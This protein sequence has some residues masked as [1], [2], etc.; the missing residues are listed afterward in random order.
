[1]DIRELEKQLLARYPAFDAESWDHVG[2]SVGDPAAQVA[3]VTCALDATEANIR[4]AHDL[5]ANVLLTHH[6]V[7]IKAPTCFAPAAPEIPQCSSALYTAAQLGV[8]II[9]LHT[10]LD[11]SL[12]ARRMPAGLFG[13]T[14]ICSLENPDDPQATGLGSIFEIEEA[15]LE[16]V[17]RLAN[18]KFGTSA[19]IWGPRAKICRRLAFLGGSL[20][21]F[22]EAALANKA[23]AIITGEC[24]YHVAQDL[25]IRGLSVVL[26]GHDRSEEPFVEILANDCRELGLAADKVYTIMNPEQWW[27]ATEGEHL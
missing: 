19:R 6:P 15:P 20:G 23:D 11:R 7:Y 5:G 3:A 12:P 13:A 16:E 22:G 1:M 24:G 10:N 9:S 2:L 26:L 17:A 8:A 18:G 14:A 21:D 27:T 25:A 4:R